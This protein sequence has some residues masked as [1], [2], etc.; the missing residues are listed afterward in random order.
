MAAG[1]Q[2]TLRLTIG[3]PVPGVAYSLQNKKSEPVGMVVAGQRPL[4]FD[5][6]VHVAP[7]PRFLGEFVRREGPMRRAHKPATPRRCGIG[8]PRLISTI[9]RPNSWRKRLLA[10]SW[11]RI[12]Q[13]GPRTAVPHARPCARWGLG[14]WPNSWL[15][16]AGPFWSAHGT[17][18]ARSRAGRGSAYWG[19]AEAQR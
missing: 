13:G 1:R 12:C 9:S 10:A 17:Q 19:S 2:I 5:L 3:D 14:R 4:S 15:I 7:G 8:A 6:P 16:R 11:R 18:E